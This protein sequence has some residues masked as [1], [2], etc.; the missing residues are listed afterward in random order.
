MVENKAIVFKSCP[1]GYPNS[2][3]LRLE[4]LSVD[5]DAV[6]AGG[7]ILK[8]GV[9]SFDPYLRGRMR[10][11]EINSYSPAFT[12]NSPIDSAGVS[13]VVKSDSPD[14]KEGDIVT[15][16]VGM[17][18]YTVVPKERL[19]GLRVLDNKEGFPLSYF[20]GILGMPGLTA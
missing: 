4:T 10:P 6:P 2:D 3:N 18:E 17:E 11:A 9:V 13:K 20:L 7:V 19:G 12:L 8:N 5:L 15:G 14:F 1:H 16:H